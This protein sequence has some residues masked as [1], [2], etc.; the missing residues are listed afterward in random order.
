MYSKTTVHVIQSI[1]TRIVFPDQWKVA[2]VIA[3]FKKGDQSLSSN[4]R[5]VSLL[6]VFSSFKFDIEQ[7]YLLKISAFSMDSYDNLKSFYGSERGG[8]SLDE[9]SFFINIHGFPI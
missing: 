8:V 6:N 9:L 7:K 3:L 1:V 2:H 5:P 4:Y